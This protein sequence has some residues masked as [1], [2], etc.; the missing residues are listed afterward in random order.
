MNNKKPNKEKKIACD[1]KTLCP[2]IIIITV[3]FSG[4]F[5]KKK[6]RKQIS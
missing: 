4:N 5:S 6:Y 3:H 1:H 2:N